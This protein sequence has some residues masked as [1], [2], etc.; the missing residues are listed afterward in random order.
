M[1]GNREIST[2][3]PHLTFHASM[4]P[5]IQTLIAAMT[6]IGELRLSIPYAL[7]VLRLGAVEA[8]VLSVVGN[9]IPVVFLLL[10]LGKASDVLSKKSTLFQRFFTWLFNR[11]QRRID[12]KYKTLGYLALVVF[13]AVPLPIT[14]AWTGSVAA[15]LL[16][17]PFWR[18]LGLIGVGVAVSG[19]IVTLASLGVVNLV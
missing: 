7:T 6:P 2:R 3:A 17:I 14:G 13:V 1:C 18:A 8:Y 19:A 5:Y 9:L 16:G 11:T 15:Y 4:H 12:K 10:F